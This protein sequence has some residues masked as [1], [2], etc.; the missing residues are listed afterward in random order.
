MC[1]LLNGTALDML[2]TLP[3]AS[4][5]CIVTSPPYWGLRKYGE[6][7]GMIGLEPTF[8]EY[9]DNLIEVFAEC[10]RVLKA[11]GTMWINMG[12]AYAGSWGGQGGPSNLSVPSKGV[13]PEKAPNR[14]GTDLPPKSLIG[15][16]WRLAFA[17][18]DMGF[19][20]RSDII[21]EK[22]T[23]MPES[24]KDRPTR[25]H[26]YIFMFAKSR[27]YWYDAKAI[28]VPRKTTNGRTPAGWDTG[29]GSHATIEHATV[30]VPASYKGS[31]PG[32]KFGP[33]QDRRSETTRVESDT[34][35]CRT[36]WTIGPEPFKGAHFAA[37]PS[38]IPRRCILAS[39]PP[40]GVVLDP[41]AGTGTTLAAAIAHGRQAIGI[42]INAEYCDLIRERISRVQLPIVFT[43]ATA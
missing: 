21:W 24:V 25:S 11:T 32:R 43:E 30:K 6:D 14:N 33:G 10:H 39:C 28:A 23:A 42:E 35:N 18:Q 3:D 31:V 36:V 4:V 5:D 26:E 20:L 22:P 2:R 12:D 37:F 40:C 8:Q 17:L 9:L 38:E 16:P 13:N 15:Q 7:P 19:I 1:E 41:F 34:R 29:P 27:R